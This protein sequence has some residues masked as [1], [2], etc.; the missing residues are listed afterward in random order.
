M[1]VNFR[2]PDEVRVST[3]NHHRQAVNL[4]HDIARARVLLKAHRIPVASAARTAT[5]LVDL[6]PQVGILG[7]LVPQDLGESLLRNR[8][9]TDQRHQFLHLDIKVSSSYLCITSFEPISILTPLSN[10]LGLDIEITV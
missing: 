4:L 6:Y 8:R 3:V 7:L 10:S 9:Y 5:R 1:V 2:A